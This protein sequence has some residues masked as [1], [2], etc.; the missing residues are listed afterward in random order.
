M[1]TQ[2]VETLI[3]GAG[4]AGLATATTCAGRPFLIVER[5]G[6]ATT[7]GSS[8]TRC[9]CTRRRSTTGCR[10]CRSRRRA[11]TSRARTRSA[12]TWS[13]TR[14]T[15]TCRCAPTPGS[16]GWRRGRNG[17]YVA[18]SRRRG[19]QLRQRGGRDRQLRP[20]AERARLRRRARPGDPAAALEPVPAARAAAT[21]SGAGGGRLALRAGH[22]LRARRDAADNPVWAEPRQHP[23]ASGVAAGARAPAGRDL[24][25]QARADPADPDGPQ[26]DAGGALPRRPAPPGQ[27]GGPGPARGAA[28]RGPDDRGRRRPAGAGRRHRAGREATSSGAPGSGRCSTGSGCRSWTSTGGRWSTAASSTR[29][30]G[31]SSAAC[32]SSTRSPRWCSRGSGGTPTTWPAGS[33]PGRPP[34]RRRLPRLSARAVR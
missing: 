21:G 13:A 16:S 31:C 6:S 2:H 32:R 33:S 9:G 24:R 20:Y 1:N 30:R 3:I 14:C 28:P 11:G 22:R 5:R 19:D 23:D 27:A 8:G 17:G 26:G 7:G 4:Q 34:R 18:F 29:R 12:T 10:G 15:S 25:V